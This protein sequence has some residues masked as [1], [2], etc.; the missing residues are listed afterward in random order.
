MLRPAVPILKPLVPI[1]FFRPIIRLPFSVRS[2]VH[3]YVEACGSHSEASSSHLYFRPKASVQC[4]VC[5]SYL[6]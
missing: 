6:R 4:E 5:G 1:Y 3:T 2:V